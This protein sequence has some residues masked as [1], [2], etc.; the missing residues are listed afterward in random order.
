MRLALV[1]MVLASP[2][3]ADG[4]RALEQVFLPGT[5]AFADAAEALAQTA[6]L[7]CQPAAV[8]PAYHAARDAWGRIGDFRLGPTEQAALTIAFWPD[9]RASG[10]R[11]LRAGVEVPPASARGFAGLDLMLGEPSLA[12]SPGDP[13]CAT[14]AA[15]TEDLRQQA[16]ALAQAWQDF[17]PQLANPGQGGIT[18]LDAAD[19]NR[20]LYTQ[21]LAA[22]D[23]T[24]TQRLGRPMERPSRA[25]H[26]RTG[27]PLPN[28]LASVLAVQT[29]A[30]A[31]A[32]GPTPQ[33]DAAV[34]G[35]QSAALSVLDPSFQDAG[36]PRARF[37]L[38]ALGQRIARLRRAIDE[39][40]GAAQGLQAGFNALDGD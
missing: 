1:L 21:L 29:L 11:A 23:L 32:D 18:Y 6:A 39:E 36:D 26:W 34:A 22:L 19:V 30:R 35:V 38:E 14:V 16:Q 12:Y 3:L 25:E 13:G 17:A 5:A 31:L 20:A 15:L 9:D 4:R 10:L 8:L 27:R 7:D 24:L 40:L 2:A 37:R 28:V 33:I